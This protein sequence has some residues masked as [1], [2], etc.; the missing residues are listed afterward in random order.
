MKQE[1]FNKICELSKLKFNDDEAKEYMEYLESILQKF[2]F[3]LEDE[4]IIE[5]KNT[6]NSL[7]LND[8]REDKTK[9]FDSNP[10]TKNCQNIIDDM[11]TIPKIINS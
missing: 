10:L 6:E 2:S 9:I 8:L 1:D 7:T 11:F 4:N 3:V 5:V